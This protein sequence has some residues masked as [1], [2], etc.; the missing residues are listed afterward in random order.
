M[1]TALDCHFNCKFP[2]SKNQKRFGFACPTCQFTSTYEK[3][4]GPKGHMKKHHG[5]SHGKHVQNLHKIIKKFLLEENYD[6]SPHCPLCLYENISHQ[7][8]FSDLV[9]HYGLEHKII[10]KYLNEREGI[11]NSFD[12]SILKNYSKPLKKENKSSVLNISENTL[13]LHHSVSSQQAIVINNSVQNLT[14]DKTTKLNTNDKFKVNVKKTLNEMQ[15]SNSINIDDKS[16]DLCKSEVKVNDSE[17]VEIERKCEKKETIEILDSDDDTVIFNVNQEID[18]NFENSNLEFENHESSD[19]KKKAEILDP[20]RAYFV[21]KFSDVLFGKES[22]GIFAKFR[23]RY[24]DPD[25]VL[26]NVVD[27]DGN[28]GHKV[29]IT[30]FQKNDNG[31]MKLM[32]EYFGSKSFSLKVKTFLWGS[33]SNKGKLISTSE[34]VNFVQGHSPQEFVEIKA[35]FLKSEK[36]GN[37]K[38]GFNFRIQ[39]KP[40]CNH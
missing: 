22:F 12:E 17:I 3:M 31:G 36:Y 7:N 34:K 16:N 6:V 37:T 29:K 33:S 39:I 32:L 1:K 20:K 28:I 8:D 25:T 19:E 35:S 26:V 24:S 27:F 30:A 18:K 40:Y 2:V 15:I 4:W 11:K 10:F 38:D 13:K 14:H 21:T 23:P 5:Q 9:R